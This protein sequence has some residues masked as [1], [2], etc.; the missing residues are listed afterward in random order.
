MTTDENPS[1]EIVDGSEV[2]MHFSLATSIGMKAVSTFGEEPF[3]FK[4]GDG[5][6]LKTLEMAILGLKAKDS[7]EFNLQPEQAY[8]PRDE[9]LVTQME[10]S[11]FPDHLKPEEGQIIG[12][13]TPEGEEAPGLVKAIS[14][15]DVTVDFNHPL[16]GEEITFIVEI[17]SV[18]NTPS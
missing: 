17:L 13:T 5:S 7:H 2:T 9:M 10:I 3:T 18:N 14:G 16:A 1:A 6:L 12:F 8:G 15:D 11:N 4:I